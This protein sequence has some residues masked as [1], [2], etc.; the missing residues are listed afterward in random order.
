MFVI[1]LSWSERF[2]K[3]PETVVIG[4]RKNLWHPRL[5]VLSRSQISYGF[6]ITWWGLIWKTLTSLSSLELQWAVRW[7]STRWQWG[8]VFNNHYSWVGTFRM[9]ACSQVNCSNIPRLHFM[10]VSSRCLY[11][12][13]WCVYIYISRGQIWWFSASFTRVIN[14]GYCRRY[15]GS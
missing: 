4:G 11:T 14:A 12:C 7:G 6:V 15:Y 8:F 2:D 5:R 3:D 1:K 10:I 9:I 13:W